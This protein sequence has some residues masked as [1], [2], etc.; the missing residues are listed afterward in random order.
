MTER[1]DKDQQRRRWL[2]WRRSRPAPH[3]LQRDVVTAVPLRLAVEKLRGFILDHAAEILEIAEH[4]VVLEIAGKNLPLI[5]RSTDRP[6]AFL[7]ELILKEVIDDHDQRTAGA[8]LRT[9]VQ[10]IIRPKR[11]RDR[12]RDT[13]DE[14]ARQLFLSLKSYLMAQDYWE[15]HR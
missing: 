9:V 12:R 3:L 1:H 15:P 10:V 4:R 6:S 13:T 7:V 2:W 5:R 8:E 14:R 11:Q